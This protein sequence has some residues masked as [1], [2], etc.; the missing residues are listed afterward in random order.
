MRFNRLCCGFLAL[1]SSTVIRAEPPQDGRNNALNNAVILVIRHAE[2]PEEGRGLSAA[3]EARASAYSNY[4]ANLMIAGQPVK[5]DYLFAAADS[6]ESQRSRL[7]LKATASV[8]G[9]KIDTR[10]ADKNFQALAD[11][12]QSS[13]H[14]P[15]ILI[16]W[17]HG[18]IP[19]LLRALGADPSQVLPNAKWPENVFH[20]LILLRYDADG[21]LKETSRIDL[22]FRPDDAKRNTTVSP[23]P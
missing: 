21:H 6:K 12:I 7:T 17:H 10:F 13:P 18:R 16:A 19:A 8:L 3:G 15:A 14:G 11:E 4:F 9:L 5:L 22:K 20:W 23:P 1:A 2:K